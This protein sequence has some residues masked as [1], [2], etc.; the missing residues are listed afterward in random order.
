MQI[1]LK[2]SINDLW[3]F[4]LMIQLVAH[5][6]IYETPIPANIEIY[7]GEFRKLVKFEIL[8]PDFI[9]G[10]FKPGLTIA[11]LIQAT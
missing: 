6:S 8:K 10:L 9:L 1:A 3:G 5:M 7:V 4:F 11:S 2:G